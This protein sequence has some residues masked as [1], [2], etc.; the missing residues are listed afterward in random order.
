MN[1]SGQKNAEKVN[2]GGYINTGSG[3]DKQQAGAE[4]GQTQLKLER[5]FSTSVNIC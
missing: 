3:N 4:L 5:G 2:I 1:N